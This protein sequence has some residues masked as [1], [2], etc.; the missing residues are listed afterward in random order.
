ML[1]RDRDQ[2]LS[3]LEDVTFGQLR[4]FACAAR[5]G[6]FA[7]AA[8]QLDISPPA[9]SAQVKILEE[10]LGRILFER[11]RGTTPLLTADGEEALEI[12]QT[13]LT[14]SGRLFGGERKPEPRVVVRVSA[15]PF[16]QENYLRKLI[17]KI[18]RAY[19]NVE[20]EFHPTTIASDVSRHVETG[21]FDLAIFAI[22]AEEE[23]PPHT[24]LICELPL[25]VIAPIGT[26]ARIA[27]GEKTL[28]D[29]Q[30]IFPGRRE[31]DARWAK[32]FLRDI[33]LAQH[34]PLMFIEHVET[35]V[36]MV[37]DGEGIGHLVPHIVADKIAAACIET[38]DIPLSPMRRLIERSPHAPAVAQAIED[39]VCEALSG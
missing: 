34:T 15:G 21:E 16:L 37:E 22:P 2:L 29:F 35:L 27:A 36:Q 11:R 33:G 14:L 25:V 19:P 7:S 10:R 12:V 39:M 17:P 30:Y 4:T 32:R 18:Y 38:L 20:I 23:M 9:V 1:M 8:E 5:A 28:E 24:R 6:S 13:I 31:T 3:V 26:R